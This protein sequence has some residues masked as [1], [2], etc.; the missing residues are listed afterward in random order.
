MQTSSH[1][2]AALLPLLTNLQKA[3]EA[4]QQQK[5]E[6]NTDINL[7]PRQAEQARAIRQAIVEWLADNGPATAAEVAEHFQYHK[8]TA[9]S[10]LN[11]IVHD[12]QARIINR[13]NL[14][15]FIVEKL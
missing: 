4:A 5:A 15:V 9:H 8:T 10:Y 13:R 7:P 1:S 14:R 12:C 2:D 6:E 11:R 3:V